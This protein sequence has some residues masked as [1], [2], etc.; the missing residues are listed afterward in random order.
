MG[1]GLGTCT[2][3]VIVGFLGSGLEV[4]LPVEPFLNVKC[5]SGSLVFGDKVLTVFELRT[6]SKKKKK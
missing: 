5:S 2:C 3:S 1:E 6:F 4:L